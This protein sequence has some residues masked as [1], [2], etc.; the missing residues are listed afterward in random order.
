MTLLVCDIAGTTIDEGGVVYRQLRESV[1]K[2]GITVTPDQVNQVKGMEKRSA[3]ITLL[4]SGGFTPSEE[5]INTTYND[6]LEGLQTKYTNNPPTPIPGVEKLLREFQRKGGKVGLTTGFQRSIAE[7]VLSAAGW[8]ARALSM[9]LDETTVSSRLIDDADN[10]TFSVDALVTS[11]TVRA[12]RPAPYLIHH[13]MELTGVTNVAEVISAGDTTADLDAATNA[14][15]RGVGVLTGSLS[16]DVLEARP[17][18]IVLDSLAD[19]DSSESLSALNAAGEA[20][21]ELD[22]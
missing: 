20:V 15:V 4:S 1:E 16:R 9:A 22:D 17:H 18:T 7:S 13:A 10:A 14:G 21:I 12:G 6:F 19:L 8:G 2:Q 5:T 3:M 11:D